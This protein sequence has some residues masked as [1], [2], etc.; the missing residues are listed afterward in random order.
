MVAFY[1]NPWPIHQTKCSSICVCC[2][3]SKLN[4]RR[5]YHS[6]CISL[7]LLDASILLLDLSLLLL[8]ASILLLDL[9]L[10][11]LDIRPDEDSGY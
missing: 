8:D 10:L 1:G 6:Y 9:S 3:I 2:R 7:L 4:V 5:M 11:L